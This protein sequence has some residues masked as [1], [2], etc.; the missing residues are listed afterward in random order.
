MNIRVVAA[1]LALSLSGC[2]DETTPLARDPS[3]DAAA[4][5]A[6]VEDGLAV[7]EANCASCHAIGATG[8]SAN[9][10]API[11]RALLA[12]YSAETLETELA[13]G[14]R[15]AHAPMPQFKF[16]PEG[17]AALVAYLRAVQTRDPGQALVEQRCAQCHAVG[18]EGTSPYPGAQPFR[19]LGRRWWRGQ[20][21]DALRTGIIAEHDR[22]DVRLPLMKLSD[23]EIDV[24]L[25]YLKTIA[26]PANPAPKAP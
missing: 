26:T 24:F 18:R 2:V 25:A 10:K 7:A 8:E 9:R 20:L 14:M 6:L 4:Q 16:K 12:R 17:A 22:A 13:E 11:F 19:N 23:A 1:V 21:R 3:A 5:A 15:V